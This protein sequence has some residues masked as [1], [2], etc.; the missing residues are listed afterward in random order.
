M[1]TQ[2]QT[3]VGLVC[4]RTT[5][6]VGL[7]TKSGSDSEKGTAKQ[8]QKK[9]K[10]KEGGSVDTASSYGGVIVELAELERTQRP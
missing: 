9:K 7:E 4:A 2:T 5:S 3:L 8:Q 1:E 10:T 6:A